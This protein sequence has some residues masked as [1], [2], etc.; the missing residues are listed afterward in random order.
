[1]DSGTDSVREECRKASK[2]ARKERM[3]LSVF[4][5]MVIYLFHPVE[6]FDIIKREREKL[7]LLTVIGLY[8]AALAARLI[9]LLVVH[10]PLADIGSGEFNLLFEVAKLL[11]P[12]FSWTVASYAISS[13]TRGEAKFTE[14]LT[15]S[16]FALI[17]YI[18]FTPIV[19]LCSNFMSLLDMGLYGALVGSITFWLWGGIFLA[20]VRM[21]DYGFLRG[22]FVGLISLIFM[23]LIWAL[24]LLLVALTIQT[25]TFLGDLWT[26][27]SMKYL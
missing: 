7:R 12:V 25:F 9:S 20:F 3:P 26:E 22:L 18:L 24:L 19:A 16:A 1:M 17:P 2:T 14:M 10:Y 15:A 27:F 5:L 4:R 8:A 11:G 6:T 13:I 23:L 21:N